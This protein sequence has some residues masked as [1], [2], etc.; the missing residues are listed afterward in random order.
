MSQLVWIDVAEDRAETVHNP[1]IYIGAGLASAL[2]LGSLLNPITALAALGWGLYMAWEANEANSDQIEAVEDGILAHLLDERQLRQYAS[3]VGL[4]QVLLELRAA[5]ARELQLSDAAGALLKGRSRLPLSLPVSEAKQPEPET[6]RGNIG[7][8]TKLGAVET[9][10]QSGEQ[11]DPQFG[12]SPWLPDALR[13]Q[14]RAEAEAAA[15]E[16]STKAMMQGIHM[17]D[18]MERIYPRSQRHHQLS[19]VTPETLVERVVEGGGPLVEPTGGAGG[20]PLVEQVVEPDPREVAEFEENVRPFCP[21]PLLYEAGETREAIREALRLGKSQNWITENLFE[22]T[23]N[24]S[25]YNRAVAIIKT[26]KEG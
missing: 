25:D 8:N 11:E 3:E 18:Q 5:Q 22:V 1:K 7:S 26:I 10:A 21:L 24:T 4:A 13:Q 19:L 6:Q 23:K 12:P 2:V 15:R 9:Q 20:G 14:I 17:A 16:Q